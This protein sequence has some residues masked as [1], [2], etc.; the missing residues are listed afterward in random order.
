MFGISNER[1]DNDITFGITKL[2]KIKYFCF[3]FILHFQKIQN[4][5]I[6]ENDK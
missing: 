1:F 2:I 3:E 6:S 4:T 5:Q